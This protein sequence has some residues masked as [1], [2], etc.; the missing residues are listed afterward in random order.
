MGLKDNF[1]FVSIFLITTAVLSYIAYQPTDIK[2]GGPNFPQLEY[3]EE[4]LDLMAEDLGIKISYEPFNDIETH[5][6][7]NPDHNLDIALIPNP[8]GVVNLGQRGIAL[9][10][11]N[12]L[13]SSLMNEIFTQHLQEI[14]T[15]K[16][17]NQ[18]Y[19]AWFRLLPNSLVWYDVSKY[20]ALGSPTFNSYEDMVKFT[21]E[22]SYEDSP[23]WC[24]DIESG[25]ST[26][27][28]ATNWLEDTILHKFGPSVYD[29]WFKQDKLSSTSEITLSILE[30]GKLI[31]I[32]DAVYG[33]NKRMVR[34]EF[35]N[36]YRNLLDDS[37]SCT[38]SWSGHFASYFFPEDT[39]YGIDYDF[40]KLP[41]ADNKNAM[42][43]IGD[44]LIGLN[45]EANTSKVINL[46]VS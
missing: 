33:G 12:Y 42:V 45:M 24:M 36:N 30:I 15:S 22:N 3:F 6:I 35:R 28:I 39:T 38:F 41:S 40:F 21:K 23:L 27:W 20:E 25:A 18:N 7:K 9:P 43:G 16:Q 26:G 13:D 11:V 29:E 14:T 10:I 1:K 44:V 34:K 8:Q 2:I 5:L 46:L 32:E 19:G 17:D 37:N 4:E 31:F